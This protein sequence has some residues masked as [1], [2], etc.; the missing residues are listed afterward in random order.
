MKRNWDYIYIVIM[1][2]IMI[3]SFNSCSNKNESTTTPD[4]NWDH[5]IFGSSGPDSGNDIILNQAGNY[6]VCGN[7]EPD[8]S[9]G[10]EGWVT[11]IDADGN[12]L[13]S[14]MYGGEENDVLNSIIE[15][16]GGSGYLFAGY[17]KSYSAG[18][19]D[20]WV[21]KTDSNGNELWS[22]N[23]GG[24]EA[25]IATDIIAVENGNFVVTGYTN[26][27]KRADTINNKINSQVLVLKI[28]SAGNEIWSRSYGGD[29]ADKGY[30]VC[31]SEEEN[32]VISGQTSS[33]G[34][35][36][37]DILLLKLD[38][39]G[40]EIW[41]KTFG[42][43]SSE[44]GRSII[45]DSE[46][47][48]II[49]GYTSSYGNGASDIWILKTDKDG[50]ELWNRC[51]GRNASDCAYQVIEDSAGD[52]VVTGYSEPD[53]GGMPDLILAVI[54]RSGNEDEIIY[55]VYGGNMPDY[56]YSLV[57]DVE[58]DK[59]IITGLTDSYGE[60][61]DMWLVRFDR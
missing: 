44:S 43:E 27:S 60:L 33:S 37:D 50:N 48:F 17:T 54:P 10:T 38:P 45:E 52:Y 11:E 40:N 29:G 57:E 7:S 1:L 6:I 59:Y 53:T 47:N 36:E 12:T 20:V 2:T 46:S 16:P 51:T 13:W 31:W 30:S 19:K 4:E 14:H 55:T 34:A 32:Y 35:G 56:G 58:S 9:L 26:V 21:V 49:T 5:K 3:L 42:G 39:G 41:T 28:D 25:D 23:F 22:K 18:F 15:L 8:D 61:G 24:P